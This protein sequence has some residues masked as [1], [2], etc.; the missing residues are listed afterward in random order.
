[1]SF[2]RIGVIGAGAWGT[3]LALCAARAGCDTVLWGRDSKVMQSIASSGCNGR[4]LPE[5]VLPENLKAVSEAEELEGSDLLLAAV[6]AQYLAATIRGLKSV[7]P[8]VPILLCAKGIDRQ[9]GEF[10]SDLL[11]EILPNHIIGVLSGP[12]FAQ[13]VAQ[14]L[15]TAVSIAFEKMDLAQQVANAI[16]SQNFRLYSGTDVRGVEIGSALKNVFAI[17]AG[18]VT[19]A[20]LGVSARAALIARSFAEMQR[21]GAA[22]GA[23]AETFGGLSGLGD[24]VLT[25][26]SKQSR[27]LRYGIALGEGADPRKA[28]AEL[29]TIEGIATASAAAQRAKKEK[30]DMPITEAIANITTGAE[31]IQDA[32]TRLLSRPLKSEQEWPI[33]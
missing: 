2:Q 33:G 17:A 12:G 24:L 3:A 31:S 21:F 10:L 19:G 18:I 9:N 16:S 6:P 14:N 25:A 13:D 15:P 20:G 7:L 30:I 5:I 8:L 4:Y 32:V 28:E 27:N 1:M 29:G 23:K 11:Q 22:Q 26:T